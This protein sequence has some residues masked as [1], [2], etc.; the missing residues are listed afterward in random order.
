M[1]F[2]LPRCGYVHE[3][4]GVDVREI[5]AAVTGDRNSVTCRLCLR[6]VA[7]SS[8]E[9]G[10]LPE[11]EHHTREEL[12]VFL[13]ARWERNTLEWWHG[14]RPLLTETFSPGAIAWTSEEEE[15]RGGGGGQMTKRAKRARRVRCTAPQ[16][17]PC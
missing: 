9:L 5:A 10:I 8:L 11:E 12:T 17:P 14:A 3:I 15:E 4:D 6:M 13:G 16:R 1:S 2:G 7:R